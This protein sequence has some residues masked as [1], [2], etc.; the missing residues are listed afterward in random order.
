MMIG[1]GTPMSQSNIPRPMGFSCFKLQGAH[2]TGAERNRSKQFDSNPL[3]RRPVA[4]S[5]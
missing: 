5:K 4:K 3:L 2:K 1:I